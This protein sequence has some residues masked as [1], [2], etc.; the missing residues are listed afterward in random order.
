MTTRTTTRR[1][2]PTAA[3][4]LLEFVTLDRAIKDAEAGREAL[5]P[6]AIAALEQLNGSVEIDGCQLTL[7]TPTK[8]VV[9][10]EILRATTSPRLFN[11]L[12][13]RTP[14]L[15]Q[16]RARLLTSRRE[17]RWAGAVSYETEKTRIVPTYR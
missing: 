2:V 14:N 1:Q 16:V 17:P 9:D 15:E 5:K 7:S 3:Q 13:N 11:E 6:A 8:T 12:T 10:L 4:T